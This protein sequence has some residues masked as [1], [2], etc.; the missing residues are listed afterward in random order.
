M[1]SSTREQASALSMILWRIHVNWW[2]VP[3]QSRFPWHQRRWRLRWQGAVPLTWKS[4]KTTYSAGLP[5]SL[6]NL[7]TSLIIGHDILSNFSSLEVFFGDQQP[8]LVICSLTSV[9]VS[10]VSLF[11]NLTNDCRP[12]AKKSRRH[13][14]EESSFMKSDVQ[15]LLEDAIIEQSSSPYRAQVVVTSSANHKKRMVID[16]SQIINWFTL[17]DS[18]PLPR[19]G[20]L[21]M[22]ASQYEV[23][24]TID[25]HSA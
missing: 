15:S 19:I 2:S 7:C 1:L 24:S 9:L 23:F 10:P 22:K 13:T 21:I 20:F 4:L 14:S 6:R 16:Y 8:K 11:A 5:C 3:Q 12:I 17:L 18:Y 25:L